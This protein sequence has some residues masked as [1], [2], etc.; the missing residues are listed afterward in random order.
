MSDS[1][2]FRSLRSPA[3][4]IVIKHVDSFVTSYAVP[5]R[6]STYFTSPPLP[7]PRRSSRPFV[8]AAIRLR[9]RIVD[10][11]RDYLMRARNCRFQ[12]A[13]VLIAPFFSMCFIY[14][15]K[16]EIDTKRDRFE[17]SVPSAR[18]NNYHM[19]GRQNSS[20]FATVSFQNI[21]NFLS[22]HDYII[23]R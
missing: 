11:C 8:A 9:R 2:I 12:P 5:P 16:L 7:I 21:N 17:N 3:P 4:S 20:D 13:L 15:A 6:S 1:Q 18:S 23:H 22:L 10:A 14:V 19:Q